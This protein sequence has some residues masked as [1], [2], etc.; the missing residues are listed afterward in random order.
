MRST[1]LF[2]SIRPILGFLRP[3]RTRVVLALLALAFTAAISLSIGQGVKLVIDTGFIAG[4]PKQLRSALGLTSI[5]IALLAL[6]TFARFYLMSWLGERVIAD[7]RKQ[8]FAKIVVLHPGYFE[9]NR[10]HEISSRLTTD[11]T[12]LQSIIGSSLSMALRSSLTLVG[13]LIM[14][15]ITNIKL[16]LIVV[17]FVPL[18]LLPI[19]LFGRR[20]RRLAAHSQDAIADVGSY[21]GEVIQNIKTVQSFTREKFEQEAF[22]REVDQAFNVAKQRIVQRAALIAVA[23]FLVFTA[24]CVMLWIGGTDVMN[25]VISAG[26]LGAFV[27]YAILVAMSTATFAEVY[28]E[29]QR[30][31]GASARLLDLLAVDTLIKDPFVKDLGV[32]D[33]FVKEATSLPPFS[34]QIISFNE[35]SFH[36]PSRPESLALHNVNLRIKPGEV[37][38]IVGPSGAG[39]STLFELMQR[40]Y[41]PQEGAIFIGDRDIRDITLHDLRANI[42][43]VA[44]NSV[45]FS[46]DIAHNIRY[47]NP[48]ATQAMVESAARQAYAHEFI[49]GLP[50]GYASFVGEQGVRLSGGQIQRIAIARAI[51]KDPEVLLLDEATSALDSQSEHIV[52]SALEALMV[53]RTT[54]VI[55]HRFST[56]KNAHRIVVMD[57]GRIQAIGNHRELTDQS[58]LYRRLCELQLSR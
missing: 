3:Y 33:L 36:Y 22:T 49:E 15:L 39:K 38:A 41:D 16:T 23:I 1:S 40:F 44:Q 50:C 47:G 30:A 31:A 20:V 17:G 14:L 37:V 19:I 29:L 58:D 46:A 7:I 28:G 4:S 54:L 26:E 24:I 52:Q 8:V 35:V 21:A 25:G 9:E 42:G 2:A 10:S 27:F 55:A 48:K 57:Q 6:G 12:L 43:V 11:T 45:L 53:K 56:V 51:L 5:L 32:T 18:V 34:K 13:G